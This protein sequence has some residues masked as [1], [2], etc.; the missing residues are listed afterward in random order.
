MRSILPLLF[1]GVLVGACLVDAAGK[2][3]AF[4]VERWV[5]STPLTAEALRG[6]VVLLDI[7]DRW[8]GAIRRSGMLRRGVRP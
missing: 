1:A 4:T 7:W 2:L 5:N 8:C 3:P 6:K